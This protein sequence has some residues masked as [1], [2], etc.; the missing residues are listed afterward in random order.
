MGIFFRKMWMQ[1]AILSIL[2]GLQLGFLLH[3]AWNLSPTSDEPVHLLSGYLALEY[4]DFTIDTEHPILPKAW[5]ALPLLFQDIDMP[6]GLEELRE[7][8]SNPYYD[9]RREAMGYADEWFFQSEN[10]P[11]ELLFWPRMMMSLWAFALTLS[12]WWVG[13]RWFGS[14]VGLLS[15]ASIALEPNLLAHGS[16][17]NTDVPMALAALWLVFTWLWL[18]EDFSSRKRRFI[19]LLVLSF[20]FLTKHSA[21]S[22]APIL[23]V[24]WMAFQFRRGELWR[25]ARWKE[26]FTLGLQ[27]FLGLIVVL[28]L[29]YGLRFDWIGTKGYDPDHFGEAYWINELYFLRFVYFPWE[30]WRGFH[31]VMREALFLPRPSYILGNYEPE[32][33]FWYFYPVSYLLKTPLAFLSLLLVPLFAW[34]AGWWPAAKR[35][36]LQKRKK[37]RIRHLVG[38]HWLVCSLL[39]TLG[40]FGLSAMNANFNIGLRHLFPVYPFIMLLTAF[41]LT[42]FIYR[43]ELIPAWLTSSTVSSSAEKITL[44]PWIR[45]AGQAWLALALSGTLV[46]APLW[47]WNGRGESRSASLIGY[48]NG[49][50]DDQNAW[51]LIA[52]SSLDWR[53]EAYFLD[54]HIRELAEE[55]T[56]Y[57]Y[58][59]WYGAQYQHLQTPC[60][61]VRSLDE[62]PAGELVLIA[63]AELQHPDGRWLWDERPEVQLGQTVLG[64]RLE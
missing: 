29:V 59:H 10:N 64:F 35:F 62:V 3:Q 56:V 2:L 55:Q 23:L 31:L 34:L 45:K 37:E 12:V 27:L 28:W 43:W 53:Q 61:K 63:S 42:R 6:S 40:I 30:F 15:A 11:R 57:C 22:F 7:I 38:R 14:A 47:L 58:S 54:E 52:D 60:V 50:V 39:T 51:K 46:A 13:R 16:L 1:L 20:A 25:W 48:V 17:V 9:P 26:L 49:L 4:G 18:L 24:L 33:A 21:I 36:W 41:S 5:A 8:S 19:F 32:G 44:V